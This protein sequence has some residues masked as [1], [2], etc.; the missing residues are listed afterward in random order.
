MPFPN[1]V[2]KWTNADGSEEESAGGPV[3]A[4]DRQFL[5]VENMF[6]NNVPWDDPA[7]KPSFTIELNKEE[8]LRVELTPDSTKDDRKMIVVWKQPGPP[9]GQI[10][11]SIER[12][13]LPLKDEEQVLAVLRAYLE[14]TANLEHSL[15]WAGNQPANE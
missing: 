8:S 3:G 6:H 11:S 12:H 14:G 10:T 7:K 2:V 13:S 9:I 1:A 4:D 5:I 15:E